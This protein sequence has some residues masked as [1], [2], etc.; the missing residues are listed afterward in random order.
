MKGTDYWVSLIIITKLMVAYPK[1]VRGIEV[2]RK[3]DDVM[4]HVRRIDPLPT[5]A[6]TSPFDR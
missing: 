1:V 2:Q 3:G 6:L 5:S 4:C